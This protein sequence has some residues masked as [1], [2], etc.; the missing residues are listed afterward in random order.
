MLTPVAPA[1]DAN[2]RNDPPLGDLVPVG[3]VAELFEL[4]E[5]VGHELVE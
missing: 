2:A 3:L 5:E 1:E 4:G